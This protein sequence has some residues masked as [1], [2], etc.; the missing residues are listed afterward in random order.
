MLF[1]VIKNTNKLSGIGCKIKVVLI[2]SGISLIF[3]I[4]NYDSEDRK[5]AIRL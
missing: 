5:I 3:L 4:L 2:E 1:S